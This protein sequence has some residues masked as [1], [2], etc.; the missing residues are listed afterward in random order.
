[1]VYYN[2]NAEEGSV[3]EASEKQADSQEDTI[4]KYFQAHPTCLYSPSWFQKVLM[5]QTPITSIRRAITNLANAGHLVKTSYMVK[6]LYHKKEHAW[7]LK[8]TNHG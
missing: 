7:Q 6:G 5:P 3:L 1:M 2:T 8:E 4:L